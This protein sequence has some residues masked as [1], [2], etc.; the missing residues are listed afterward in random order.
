MTQNPSRILHR[1][2]FT[3][4]ELLSIVA[5]VAMLTAVLLPS[6]LKLR[7]DAQ[8]QICLDNQRAIYKGVQAYSVANNDWLLVSGHNST[9]LKSDPQIVYQYAPTWSRVVAKTL[10]IPFIYEQSFRATTVGD[11]TFEPSSAYDSDKMSHSYGSRKRD[12][13]VLRCPSENFANAWKGTNSTSYGWNTNSYGMGVSDY[14]NFSPPHSAG[15]STVRRRIQNS[16]VLKP[17]TTFMIGEHITADGMYDYNSAQFEMSNEKDGL[18]RFATYHENVSN[19]LWAD[20]HTTT[21]TAEDLTKENFMR[22][23]YDDVVVGEL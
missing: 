19:V 22:I 15:A 16:E 2:A 23:K 8:A 18:S 6:L 12:N 13:G 11:K 9:N 5:A 14:F 21:I 10:D 20:G 1:T 3:L 7:A 17:G 4:I